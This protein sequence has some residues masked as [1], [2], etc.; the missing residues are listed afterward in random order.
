MDFIIC[1]IAIASSASQMHKNQEAFIF[2][3]RNRIHCGQAKTK[4]IETKPNWPCSTYYCSMI[5]WDWSIRINA[6]FTFHVPL[7]ITIVFHDLTRTFFVFLPCNI[8]SSAILFSFHIIFTRSLLGPS[9]TLHCPLF[10]ISNTNL[11]GIPFMSNIPSD[12]LLNTS[13]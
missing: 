12:I 3:R 8:P 9:T 7:N 5:L 13:F 1:A 11:C 6:T 10:H 2:D 4:Y